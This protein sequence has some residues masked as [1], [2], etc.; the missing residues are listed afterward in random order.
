MLS[1]VDRVAAEH[2]TTLPLLLSGGGFANVKLNMEI[3]RRGFPAVFVCPPIG[4]QGLAIGAPALRLAESDRRDGLPAPPAFP[5]MFLGADADSF[6]ADVIAE[7]G[8][9]AE[10][11]A[12]LAATVAGA[13]ASSQVVA[14]ARGRAEFGPRALGNRSVLYQAA[15]RACSPR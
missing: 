10:R 14:I 6:V 5:T 2:G 7:S 15:L 9:I 13:L 8:L 4:D 11:S 12:D 3:T 1:V